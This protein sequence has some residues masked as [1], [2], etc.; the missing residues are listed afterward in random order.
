MKEKTFAVS[1]QIH[2]RQR[3]QRQLQRCRAQIQRPLIVSKRVKQVV[4]EIG[5]PL[6]D[7]STAGARRTPTGE[8]FVDD[9]RRRRF[10]LEASD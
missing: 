10:P 6:F 9:A 7:C 3:A 4:D 2:R 1:S 8:E 5:I